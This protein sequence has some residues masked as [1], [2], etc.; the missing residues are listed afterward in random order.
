MSEEESTF[1]IQITAVTVCHLSM[2]PMG[3]YADLGCDSLTL[4]LICTLDPQAYILPLASAT[5]LKNG[6]VNVQ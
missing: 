5:C 4:L 6:V 3:L 2:K 1:A